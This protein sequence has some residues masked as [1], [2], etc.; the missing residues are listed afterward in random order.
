[1]LR[2]EKNI[3]L[4]I[5]IDIQGY[6]LEALKGM[7]KQLKYVDQIYLE[8]NFRQ[9]YRNC[10]ELKEIDKVLKKFNFYRVGMYR[11]N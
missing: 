3:I 4:S 8:V 11:T 1:M 6:E 7:E 9:V 2:E 5:L 10:S